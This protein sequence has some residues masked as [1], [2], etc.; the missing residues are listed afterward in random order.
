MQSCENERVGSGGAAMVKWD[1]ATGG[2]PLCDFA[3]NGTTGNSEE[4]MCCSWRAVSCAHYYEDLRRCATVPLREKASGLGRLWQVSSIDGLDSRGDGSLRTRETGDIPDFAKASGRADE[5][6]HERYQNKHLH[7]WQSAFRERERTNGDTSIT[8]IHIC[9]PSIRETL[10]TRDTGHGPAQ[11]QAARARPR[12]ARLGAVR[13]LGG[14][15]RGEASR[16]AARRAGGEPAGGC[17]PQGAPGGQWEGGERPGEER[18]E[19]EQVVR[20][21][22]QAA[23]VALGCGKRETERLVCS[24]RRDP[25]WAAVRPARGTPRPRGL[26][27]KSLLGLPA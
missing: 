8:K 15:A 19:E 11:A 9:T 20:G 1:L 7:N 14:E 12:L 10:A 27:T 18:G 5:R 21:W 6:R 25:Y 3:A 13:A 24:C 4:L 26:G 2:S 16:A 22:A 23:R 17:A